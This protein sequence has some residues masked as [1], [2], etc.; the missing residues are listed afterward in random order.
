MYFH[1]GRGRLIIS[2]GVLFFLCEVD[3]SSSQH[4]SVSFRHQSGVPEGG[5]PGVVFCHPGTQK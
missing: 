3:I 2:F 1:G 5:Q 4:Q